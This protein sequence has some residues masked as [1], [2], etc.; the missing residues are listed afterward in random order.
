MKILAVHSPSTHGATQ[1]IKDICEPEVQVDVMGQWPASTSDYDGIIVHNRPDIREGKRC[2]WYPCGM[3][4]ARMLVNHSYRDEIIRRHPCAIWTNSM[5]AELD[6]AEVV[7]DTI[8]VKCM[9]KPFPLEIPDEAPALT[10]AKRI[11]WYWKP[12][13]Q[14]T[15]PCNEQIFAAMRELSDYEIWQISNKRQGYTI[16]APGCEH[17]SPK[18]RIEPLS[19]AMPHVQGMVRATDGL[20]FG[21]STYQVLAYGR[22]VMYVNLQDPHVLNAKSF[23]AVPEL[24]RRFA[25]GWSYY[26]AHYANE[27]IREFF[28]EEALK[29]QWIDELTRLFGG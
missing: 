8:E 29:A 7:P 11:L 1:R 20:D 5:Q 12:D 6:V 18:G 10:T 15:D 16:P 26:D 24:V 19:Q 2:V 21:R 3:P 25:N 13:W 28:T 27:Y 23:A 14:Y 9:R 22:W 17:V 4:Q